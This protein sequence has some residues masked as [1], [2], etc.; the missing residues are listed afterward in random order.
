MARKITR[1]DAAEVVDAEVMPEVVADPDPY[2]DDEPDDNSAEGDD[3]AEPAKAKPTPIARA[4]CACGCGSTPVGKASKF[5]SGHDQRFHSAERAAGRTPKFVMSAEKRI[6]AAAA[7]RAR[8]AARLA[9]ADEAPTLATD[10]AAPVAILDALP[11]QSGGRDSKVVARV[12][13]VKKSA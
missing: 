6:K 3:V 2:P 7:T 11:K 9:P 5:L 8:R 13:R 10:L 12:T 4:A 1:A